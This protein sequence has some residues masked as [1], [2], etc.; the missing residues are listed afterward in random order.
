MLPYLVVIIPVL[1]ANHYIG[2]KQITLTQTAITLLGGNLFIDNPV[3]V[4]AWY[5]TFILLLYTFIWLQSIPKEKDRILKFGAWACGYLFFSNY[6]NYP[7]YFSAFAL[8]YLAQR[9]HLP[10]AKTDSILFYIQG[11]CY[12]FF[13]IHGAV[14]V[15][16]QYYFDLPVWLF[17]TV[18]FALSCAGGVTLD[19]VV[20]N[21][22]RLTFMRFAHES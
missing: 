1:I 21:S 15:M 10:P 20:C 12:H 6:L 17:F 18:G 2:Y 4:I 7:Y 13:L 5:V 16:L 8:G 14:L 11:K 9:L 19:K 3:Y 22:K